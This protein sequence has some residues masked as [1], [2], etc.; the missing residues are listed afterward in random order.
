MH[1]GRRQLLAGVGGAAAWPLT[2]GAQQRAIPVIGYLSD[3]AA[4]S[5]ASMLV[6]VRR[7]LGDAGYAEGR[8]VAIEYRFTEGRHDRIPAMAADLVSSRVA[9]IVASDTAAALAVKATLFPEL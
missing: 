3:R 7:G 2:A 5:D 4:E 9:V 1:I 8:N 6:A